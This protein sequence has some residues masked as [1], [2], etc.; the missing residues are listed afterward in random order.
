MQVTAFTV[1]TVRTYKNKEGEKIVEDTFHRCVAFS[2]TA[3]SISQFVK[4]DNYIRIQGRMKRREHVHKEKGELE[5]WEIV[6]EQWGFE[7]P[8]IKK[9]EGSHE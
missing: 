7:G 3:E 5:I 1:K 9:G 8:A 2:K 6:V 4:D